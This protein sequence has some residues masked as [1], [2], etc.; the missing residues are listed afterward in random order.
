MFY[1]DLSMYIIDIMRVRTCVLLP[2]T[3]RILEPHAHDGY[4]AHYI[5]AGRGSF[6]L[7][8]RQLAVRPGDFFY[9]CPGTVHRMHVPRNDY[10]LQYIALLELEADGELAEDLEARVGEGSVRRLGDR[11]HALFAQISRRS[12]SNDARARRAASAT[13]A[14]F[15]YELIIDAPAIQSSH[16]A[17]TRAL[18]FMRS[19]VGAAFGLDELVNEVGLEKSYF[20]RLFKSAIGMPPMKYAMNLK[21]SAAAD[22]LRSTG[23][24][25][26]AVAARVGFNDEY[27]FAKRFKQ[28][29]GE[30]PGR[31]RRQS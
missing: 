31:Y 29:S 26:A 20:V 7:E 10:L 18:D 25:L 12:L 22:L 11:H 6:E 16:P 5:V 30:A 17:V 21:M 3:L 4:E 13:M 2:R 8:G 14:S 24:P 27:H 15:L 28:W 19:H 1:N 9:T 23:E